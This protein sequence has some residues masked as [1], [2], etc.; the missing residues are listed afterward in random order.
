MDAARVLV[1]N[2]ESSSVKLRVVEA[3]DSVTL[4]EDLV[5][6]GECRRLL[7]GRA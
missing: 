7:A 6:A 4:R 2:A 1:V 3:D 5:I